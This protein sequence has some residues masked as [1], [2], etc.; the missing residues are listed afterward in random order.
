MNA[1]FRPVRFGPRDVAMTVRADGAL[2][3]HAREELARYPERST[4]RLA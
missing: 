2:L 1:P 4:E 3:L